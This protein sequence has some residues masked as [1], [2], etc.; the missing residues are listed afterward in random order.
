VWPRKVPTGCFLSRP[1]LA[2][3]I[4]GLYPNQ[5]GITGNNVPAGRDTEYDNR[6]LAVPEQTVRSSPP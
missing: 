3:I 4:T 5:H 1:S 6:I 2:S